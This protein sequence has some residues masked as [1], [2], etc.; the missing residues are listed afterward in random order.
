MSQ[1][2]AVVDENG[3]TVN[4]IIAEADFEPGEG[5]RLVP[6]NEAKPFF[7][8]LPFQIVDGADKPR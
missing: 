5:L 3:E 1:R 4:L 2:W 7:Q 6:E 8:L